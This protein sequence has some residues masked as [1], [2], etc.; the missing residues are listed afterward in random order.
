MFQKRC[1][2]C[3]GDSGDGNGPAAAYLYPRPRDYRRG[4]FK[5]GSTP[6][7]AKPRREDL[8]R[9]VRQGARGTLMPDFKFLS[10][11][12]LQAV[13]DYVLVLTHR[14]SWNR[15]WPPRRM[16]RTRSTRPKRPS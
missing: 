2:G 7:G 11:E 3:H 14:G 5:F 1:V 6:Y 16:M 4:I 10:D 9:V 15:C 12:D 13:V 8:V